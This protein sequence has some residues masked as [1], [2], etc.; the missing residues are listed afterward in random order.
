MTTQLA[1]PVH[2]EA[3]EQTAAPL[4]VPEER[5]V[6]P[7]SYRPST[8]KGKKG[9]LVYVTPV[10]AG[11]LRQLASTRTAQCR[12]S[13]TRP[14]RISW[15]SAD[16]R[17][18]HTI[19]KNLGLSVRF[20]GTVAIF[21]AAT[22]VPLPASAQMT[23]VEANEAYDQGRIDQALE[24][25][26]FHAEQGHPEAQ[27]KRGRLHFN[28]TG[29]MS[30]DPAEAAR[31][32]RLSA[33]QGYGK[34]Q[35]DLAGLYAKGEGVPKDGTEAERWLRLAAE[36]GLADAQ[37]KLGT[38]YAEGDGV[39]KDEAEAMRWYRLVA[40][41]GNL[42]A[43]LVV[44]LYRDGEGFPKDEADMIHRLLFAAEQGHAIAQFIVGGL[45]HEGKE[46]PKDEAEA[47]RWF[48]RALAQRDPALANTLRSGADTGDASAQFYFGLMHEVGRTGPQDD[49]EAARWY[50]LA[51]EQG[52][53]EAQY[54]LG[55]RYASGQ[56]VSKNPVEAVRWFEHAAKKGSHNA[57]Y[58]LGTSYAEGD[59]IPED[60]V[61]AYAW[62]N[63][64]AAQGNELAKEDKERVAKR[65]TRTQLEKAQ[66][67]ARYLWKQYVVPFQ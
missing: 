17:R 38:M 39:P 4:P 6:P 51:A 52:H 24:A 2:A 30:R 34:A 67:V 5:R 14:S 10:L 56:G 19:M 47:T 40:E 58:K 21:L 35:L 48:R 41:Q 32:Y 25:F 15:S 31:W 28:G 3:A 46:F 29:G 61:T 1:A 11:Q 54:S 22:V 55:I 57:Q 13:G 12:P 63:I 53:A 45:Y 64:A 9:V 65:L 59:G 43:Q 20:F 49:I 18:E 66:G 44:V 27:H 33:M 16:E 36:Q 23:M 37:L 42:V 60:P 7:R 50:R 62:L 26:L 8:R